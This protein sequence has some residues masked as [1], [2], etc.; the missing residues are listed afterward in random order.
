MMR[1]RWLGLVLAALALTGCTSDPGTPQSDA[2]RDTVLQLIHELG[3]IRGYDINGIARE[4]ADANGRAT[5][6]AI[7]EQDAPTRDDTM[8]TL[9]LFVPDRSHPAPET[10]FCL[11]VEFNWYGYAG[12]FDDTREVAFVTCPE[13]PQPVVPPADTSIHLIVAENAQEVAL[14]VLAAQGEDPD[15][16]AISQAIAEQL[17]APT[18]EYEQSAP[19]RV[20]VEGQDIGVAMGDSDKCVLV[21]RVD[22][23]VADLHPAKVHLQEGEYGCRPETSLLDPELL[24]PPH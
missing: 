18:G 17:A 16:D 11:D 7:T 2:A 20:I 10:G 23:A 14:A 24:R 21:S 3:D 5:L 12:V 13:D 22:G 6:I 15:A 1:K 9:T 8:G 19:P 4:V